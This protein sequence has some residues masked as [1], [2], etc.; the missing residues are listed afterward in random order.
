MVPV[1]HSVSTPFLNVHNLQ[2]HP[3]L[4]GDCVFPENSHTRKLGEI[5]VF[6]AVISL[7]K[8]YMLPSLLSYFSL[9]M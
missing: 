9:H 1:Q 6:Y 7:G 2:N 5:M 8:S 3:K 4:C